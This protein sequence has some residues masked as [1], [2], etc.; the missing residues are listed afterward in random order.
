MI[1]FEVKINGKAVCIAGVGES[2]VL[3]A[4]TNWVRRK[5]T[6][7]EQKKGAEDDMGSLFLQVGGLMHL[8]EEL[9]Q[10]VTWLDQSL[11]VGDEITITIRESDHCDEPGEK[12]QSIKKEC[13]FCKK[14]PS[15]VA[16]VIAGAQA[17]ICNECVHVAGQIITG[18]FQQNIQ[19]IHVEEQEE[20]QCDFC[21]KP[22]SDVDILLASVDEFYICHDCVKVCE[23][24][25]QE[26]EESK[27]EE[28]HP[29]EQ[30]HNVREHA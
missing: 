27:N 25:I 1:C 12:E 24:V 21:G 15:D 4:I 28:K 14:Q 13:S 26:A 17:Y 30:K 6:P 19:T 29:R 5:P 2:G 18:T 23:D 9:N 22:R 3:S 8:E 16:Q 10:H 7:E 11:S 20:R